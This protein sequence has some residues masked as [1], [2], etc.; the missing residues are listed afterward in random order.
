MSRGGAKDREH[1]RELV[2]RAVR[3]SDPKNPFAAHTSLRPYLTRVPK[4]TFGEG[5]LVDRE[6]W[7]GEVLD[8]IRID[9]QEHLDRSDM[10]DLNIQIETAVMYQGMVPNQSKKRGVPRTAR[11]QKVVAKLVRTPTPH[12]PGSIVTSPDMLVRTTLADY[13]SDNATESFLIL[14]LSIRN[15]LIGYTEYNSG[16]V[17][18][19][20]VNTSGVFRDALGV[21]AAGIVTVHNHPTGD[22]TPSE[23]DRRLWARL[24]EAGLIVGVPVIDNLIVG[25][26]LRYF[27]ES[28]SEP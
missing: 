26:E 23:D 8:E 25:S 10:K 18:G 15:E 27:S 9:A 7:L 3:W 22:P 6:F 13:L 5:H 2:Q 14:F 28:E 4:E 11:L 19:V 21:G 17:S 12:K 1:Y 20:E 16:G 24:R